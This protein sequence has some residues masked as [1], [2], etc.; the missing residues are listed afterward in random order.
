MYRY[1]FRENISTT[2]HKTSYNGAAKDFVPEY[3]IKPKFWQNKYIE[4]EGLVTA[5][6]KIN[7]IIINKFFCDFENDI[8]ENLIGKSIKIKGKIIGYDELMD[9]YKLIN[10]IVI[11]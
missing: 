7:C 8:N 1:I 10:C 3:N 6:N 9:E 4:I 11:R 5:Y 2:L